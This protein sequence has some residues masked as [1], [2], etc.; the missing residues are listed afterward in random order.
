MS[1][2]P[3]GERE[4]R[5]AARR[6]FTFRT[7]MAAAVIAVVVGVWVIL[8]DTI[9]QSSTVGSELFV[10]VSAGALIF[11]AFAGVFFTADCISAE[12][13]EGTL[14]LLF[15]TELRGW[16][17]VI[18]KLLA[19]SLNAF[20]GV[21]AMV[22]VMAI[23][24]LAGGVTLGEFWRV[25]LILG[26]TLFLSLA[27]GLLV[28]V[29]GRRERVT[30]AASF[31]AVLLLGVGLPVAR[32]LLGHFNLL[33]AIQSF[34]DLASPLQS[35]LLAFDG[36]YW[37]G[38]SQFWSGLVFAHGCAWCLLIIAG[39][40]LERIWRD[41]VMANQG[42]RGQAAL[43]PAKV[44]AGWQERAPGLEANAFGWLAGRGWLRRDVFWRVTLIVLAIW[45]VALL[46]VKPAQAALIG[47]ATIMALHTLFKYWLAIEAVNRL[48]TDRD[49]GTLDLVLL[50]RLAARDI[51]AGQKQ[52][53]RQRF[54]LP[55]VVVTV[56][57]VVVCAT[58]T[59][60]AP[61]QGGDLWLGAFFAWAVLLIDLPALAWCGMA[62][63]LASGRVY[64]AVTV[65]LSRVLLAPVLIFVALFW[66]TG[67]RG[68]QPLELS[69]AW[70]SITALSNLYFW[71][72][73]T[74]RLDLEF[75]LMIGG[76]VDEPAE[77][78]LLLAP[79]ASELAPAGR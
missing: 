59:G 79:S 5:V 33:P 1:L 16:D 61:G 21:L 69:L 72:A 13:R 17:V 39:A 73:A 38:R 7:R 9:R 12:K 11:A 76:T 37:R 65:V 63:G 20:Y 62:S 45:V 28:S 24:I 58:V 26:N 29:L 8:G 32:K 31:V 27:A 57:D 34:C 48:A 60:L 68:F 6:P 64:R 67:A 35:Y 49:N 47:F 19:S 70:L 2:F 56:I 53:L 50:T 51:I 77:P 10:A 14:G 18:G 54:R 22:P 78:E 66:L 36:A 25:A 75:R 46:L 52:A 15:L 43:A 4:L 55:L 3:I 40:V 44:E 30:M 71:L 41:P 23:P 42:G 74:A